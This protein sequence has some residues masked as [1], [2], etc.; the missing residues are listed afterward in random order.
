MSYADATFYLSDYLGTD[1]GDSQALARYL[2]RASD[3]IDLATQFQIVTVDLSAQ[4]LA[5]VKKANCA[6][7]E[8]YV[9]NGDTYNDQERAESIG[10]LSFSRNKA[11]IQP[12]PTGSICARAQ[13]YLEQTGLLTRRAALVGEY[14]IY[15]DE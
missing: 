12:R 2:A 14:G 1:P 10:I 13:Q 15:T 4:N 6:Q 7:A 5:L 11:L 3:D 8:F 9:M